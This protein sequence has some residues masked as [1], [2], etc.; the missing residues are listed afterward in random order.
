MY[1]NKPFTA[2]LLFSLLLLNGCAGDSSGYK[3]Y[4]SG[5]IKNPR[6][7]YVLFCRNNTVTDTLKLDKENR[8]SIAFDSLTPGIYSFKHE[9]DFQY[10]YFDKND[11]ISVFIDADD[12]DKSVVF[13][14]KGAEKNNFMMELFTMIDTDRRNSYDS[15]SLDYKGFER[16]A[17]STHTNRLNFYNAK[18]K[19][20]GWSEGFDFYAKNRVWLNYYG[21]QEFYPYLYA[22]RNGESI[23]ESLPANYYDYRKKIDFNNSKLIHF[24]P[25]IRYCMGYATNRAYYKTFKKGGV[26]EFSIDFNLNRLNAAD[27][28]F[29]N[30]ELKNIVLDN[31][32]FGYLLEDENIANNKRFLERYNT[33]STNK[34]PDN[35]IRQLS[36]AIKDLTPG[37]YLPDVKL[38]TTDGKPYNV[39]NTIKRKTVIFFWTG[40]AR[41][42]LQ[43][44]YNRVGEL[45]KKHPEIDFVAINVD[46]D[47]EWKKNL[48]AYEHKGVT[49]VRS[50]DFEQLHH[51][52]VLNKINRTIVLNSNGTIRNAFTNLLDESFEKELK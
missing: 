16:F 21:Y 14:G 24:S 43:Q 48:G 37:T 3:A 35:E 19:E 32:A 12:F 33:L 41:V 38:I 46:N 10:V 20:L 13:S 15:F 45:Q 11:S 22:R 39:R 28:L 49:Q 8:F 31:I 17:D 29:K 5:Q 30:K 2:L 34:R 23:K 36:L 51:K 26:D 40:C 27:S 52:W 50:T 44:V 9:P 25:F 47:T 42:L 6:Q 1:L 4:F 7:P 18:K